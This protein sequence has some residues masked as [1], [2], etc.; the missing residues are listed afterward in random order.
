M[1]S[2]NVILKRQSIENVLYTKHVSL[3][4]NTYCKFLISFNTIFLYGSNRNSQDLLFIKG[5]S[6]NPTSTF[7]FFLYLLDIYAAVAATLPFVNRCLFLGMSHPDAEKKIIHRWF[8]LTLHYILIMLL[9][10]NYM[11]HGKG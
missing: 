6:D 8:V 11:S 5:Q 4:K 10:W 2:V 1:F 3:F 7:C 9:H